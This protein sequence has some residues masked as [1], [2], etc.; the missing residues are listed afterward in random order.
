MGSGRGD[1]GNQR[2]RNVK[3]AIQM[4]D[5]AR[6]RI[7][8]GGAMGDNVGGCTD[9][10][11]PRLPVARCITKEAGKPTNG[12][13]GRG[14]PSS[15]RPY[16]ISQAR[17]GVN[18]P[19]KQ[20]S[21]R[22]CPVVEPTKTHRGRG[23]QAGSP[24]GSADPSIPFRGQPL[25]S[26]LLGRAGAK[27]CTWG[28]GRG[29][30]TVVDRRDNGQPAF[31]TSQKNAQGIKKTASMGQKPCDHQGSAQ[32]TSIGTRWAEGGPGGTPIN[33]KHVG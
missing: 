10:R 7:W 27:R 21:P 19:S 12:M 22:W 18:H 6:D 3:P 33:P 16:S 8:G 26:A 25:G 9:P 29:L 28:P 4:G 11:H 2:W 32:K 24:Q 31:S 14:R 5:N 13:R 1:P 17:D 15:H 23:T 30:R 20:A